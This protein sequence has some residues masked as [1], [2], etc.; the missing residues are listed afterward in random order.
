MI[1]EDLFEDIHQL[2]LE[3]NQTLNEDLQKKK[4]KRILKSAKVSE[5]SL[6]S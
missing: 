2:P 1:V 3:L 5:T 4:K 6:G